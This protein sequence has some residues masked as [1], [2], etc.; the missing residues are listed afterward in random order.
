ML[1]AR[2]FGFEFGR[3]ATPEAAPFLDCV[4]VALGL[5]SED[6][7]A[8][9]SLLTSLHSELCFND[10]RDACRRHAKKERQGASNFHCV[11][12]KSA[13]TRGS[14]CKSLEVKDEAWTT[15]IP[16]KQLQSSVHSALRLTDRTLGIPTHGLTKCKAPLLTKPHVLG[17]RLGLL[18]CLQRT[19]HDTLGSLEDKRD[20]A[21][22]VF[23]DLW[24]SKL[25]GEHAMIRM[26]SVNEE[27]A[28]HPSLVLRAGPFTCLTIGLTPSSP[29]EPEIYQLAHGVDEK[30]VSS[31]DTFELAPAEPVMFPGSTALGYRAKG[32][33]LSLTKFV[34]MHGILDVAPGVLRSLCSKLKI[35]KSGS[36][37]HKLRVEVFLKTME[38]TPEYIASIL[39]AIPDKPSRKRKG[40]DEGE[41]DENQDHKIWL[42]LF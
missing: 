17:Q 27:Y 11:A 41:Q 24:I 19:F 31:L 30:T 14:G 40:A 33:Y 10:L 36:L 22:G 26:K 8:S 2:H 4:R 32:D 13:A 34:A 37:T 1:N 21:L 39:E 7:D 15:P 25:V 28:A 42:C 20:A 29:D 5:S 38:C 23:P 35:R 6:Q 9:D 12:M 18:R 16:K 3:V